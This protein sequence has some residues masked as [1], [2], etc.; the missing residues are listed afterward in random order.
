MLNVFFRLY[1]Y[2]SKIC[3]VISHKSSKSVTMS[4]NLLIV[5]FLVFSIVQ[6]TTAAEDLQN[7]FVKR[8]DDKLAKDKAKE[9]DKCDSDASDTLKGIDRF[10][11]I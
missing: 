2:W 10:K 4:K 9:Y 5:C 1:K 3:F 7:M 8:C 6:M 11:Q